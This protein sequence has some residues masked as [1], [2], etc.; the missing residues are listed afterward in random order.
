MNS[1]IKLRGFVLQNLGKVTLQN[2]GTVRLQ[3]LGTVTLQSCRRIRQFIAS[4]RNTEQLI[5]AQLVRKFA[6]IDGF[7][8]KP[9]HLKFHQ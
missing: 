4:T 2:L 3:N 1:R 8:L 7:D 9:A 5:C 6:V